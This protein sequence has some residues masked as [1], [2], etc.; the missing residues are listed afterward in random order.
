MLFLNL[1]PFAISPAT[2]HIQPLTYFNN[3]NAIGNTG[4]SGGSGRV[5]QLGA[6]WSH[7]L[8]SNINITRC[9]DVIVTSGDAGSMRF[10]PAATGGGC[11]VPRFHRTVTQYLIIR[12]WM[13][14]A[15]IATL[16]SYDFHDA[17]AFAS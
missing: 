14:K 3:C 7:N 16:A 9:G 6:N 5:G 10:I 1:C 12:F 2:A 4:S 15:A 8:D 11:G 13:F 17:T